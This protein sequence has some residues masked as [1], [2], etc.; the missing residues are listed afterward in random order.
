MDM[1]VQELRVGGA[2]GSAVH[3]LVVARE[4]HSG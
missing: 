2:E 4:A 1:G 3:A